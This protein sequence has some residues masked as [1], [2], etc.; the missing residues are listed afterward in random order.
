VIC[1]KVAAQQPIFAQMTAGISI[2]RLRKDCGRKDCSHGDCGSSR[3]DW[4]YGSFVPKGCASHTAYGIH[5]LALAL[6]ARLRRAMSKV[7]ET[8]HSTQ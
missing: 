4:L 5:W 1:S 8:A 3:D 6:L 7:E 2:A